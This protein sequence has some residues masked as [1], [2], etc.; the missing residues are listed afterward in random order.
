MKLT[1]L[2]SADAFNSA[3]RAHSCYLL[4]GVATVDLC[5]Q[6]RFE[7]MVLL[8]VQDR[9]RARIYQLRLDRQ[10]SQNPIPLAPAAFMQ[11]FG[12]TLGHA[13]IELL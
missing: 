6:L 11:P 4:D 9:L 3:G 5:G 2:G 10:C 12:A 8:I 13:A 7:G 1:V